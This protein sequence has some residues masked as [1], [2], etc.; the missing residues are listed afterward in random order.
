MEITD[1]F[2]AI[3]TQ[4]KIEKPTKG[5]I[6]TSCDSIDGPIIKLFNG[7]VRKLTNGSEAKKIYN[8]VE[9][10]I[11]LGD[12]LFPFSDVANRNSVLLK[13]GY[14]EE[15]WHLDLEEKDAEFAKETNPFKISFSC[16]SDI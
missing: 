4:L 12:I 9:E 10:I 14:V 5:C 11:Y 16:L 13:P 7:S 6:V 3:G 15:W 1:S 2:I 8:N